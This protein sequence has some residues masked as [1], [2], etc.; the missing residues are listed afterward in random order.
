LEESHDGGLRGN[1]WKV[2]EAEEERLKVG[3]LA[4]IINLLS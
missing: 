2:E 3:V 1:G 4:G